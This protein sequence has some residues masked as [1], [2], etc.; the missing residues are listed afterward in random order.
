MSLDGQPV[1]V[2]M[3]EGVYAALRAGQSVD[4]PLCD[5]GT[6][7][8]GAGQHGLSTRNTPG[9]QVDAVVLFSPDALPTAAPPPA[10]Q[11]TRTR[12]DRVATVQ[13]CP[14]GCW[15]VLGEGLNSGWTASVDG[16]PLGE[17]TQ[18]SGGM[19]G[20][21]L[22]PSTT[23]TEVRMHWGAQTPVTIGV[24][25]SAV[26]MLLCVGLALR[27]RRRARPE[28]R[29]VS[30]P[31]RLDGS[32]LRPVSLRAALL[33]AAAAALLTVS[34]AGPASAAGAVVPIALVVAF[35]RPRLA[36][37]AACLLFTG[38]V[39]V[40]VRRQRSLRFPAD[41]AWPSRFDDLHRPGMVVV[42]LLLAGC[43]VAANRRQAD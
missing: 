7:V 12:L 30:D 41:A 10:V 5:P 28:L 20:W 25:I 1:G 17:P 42:A 37:V 15:L 40:A 33:A 32:V 21:R 39:A 14:D 18:V 23:P 38:L 2:S 43:V 26:A 29:V 31:P 19:N 4:R 3:D 11:V 34:I 13:P 6:F 9:M 27:V 16:V 36:A 24:L 8:L 22:P 35:R